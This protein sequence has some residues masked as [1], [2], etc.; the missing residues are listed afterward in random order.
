MDC[1]RSSAFKYRTLL[2]VLPLPAC[3]FS[4]SG[5][6]ESK[7]MPMG[8]EASPVTNPLLRVDERSKLLWLAVEEHTLR[9]PA[10]LCD[11]FTATSAVKLQAS[12]L[13]LLL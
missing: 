6:G 7:P 2:A 12:P 5:P 13:L 8:V 1:V 10:L 3:C 4:P 11:C 9:A